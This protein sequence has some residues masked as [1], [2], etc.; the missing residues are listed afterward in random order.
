MLVGPCAAV[1]VIDSP[2]A[3]PPISSARARALAGRRGRVRRRL[4]FRD[5]EHRERLS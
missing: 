3:A 5:T 1:P 4:A 2:V